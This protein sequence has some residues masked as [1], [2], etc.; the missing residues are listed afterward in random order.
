VLPPCSCTWPHQRRVRLTGWLSV[1][2]VGSSC[3]ACNIMSDIEAQAAGSWAGAFRSCAQQSNLD[4]GCVRRAQGMRWCENVAVELSRVSPRLYPS[5][6]CRLLATET[7]IPK[8]ACSS[9]RLSSS[10]LSSILTLLAI[11]PTPTWA[12]LPHPP[13]DS[14]ALQVVR[15]CFPTWTLLSVCRAQAGVSVPSRGSHTSPGRETHC[16]STGVT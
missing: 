2:A 15:L 4:K 1:D 3:R 6:P 9:S 12:M 16:Y 14:F 7:S 8:T 11:P 13:P 10:R 5:S